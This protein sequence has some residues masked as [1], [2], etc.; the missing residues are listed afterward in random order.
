MGCSGSRNRQTDDTPTSNSGAEQP[1]AQQSGPKLQPGQS[2]VVV[3]DGDIAE[4]VKRELG[5]PQESPQPMIPLHDGD[6]LVYRIPG[7]KKHKTRRAS[8]LW[9]RGQPAPSKHERKST[10]RFVAESPQRQCKKN[11]SE[12]AQ[13]DAHVLRSRSYMDA[14]GEF[15]SDSDTDDE[16][17]SKSPEHE[18]VLSDSQRM[19]SLS[20]GILSPVNEDTIT[21]STRRRQDQSTSSKKQERKSSAVQDLVPHPIWDPQLVA[22]HPLGGFTKFIS[23][24]RLRVVDLFRA[25]DRDVDNLITFDDVYTALIE[26]DIPLPGHSVEDLVN[27]LDENGD[28]VI[29]FPE[30]KRAIEQQKADARIRRRNRKSWTEHPWRRYSI[31]TGRRKP[32]PKAAPVEIPTHVPLTSLT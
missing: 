29:T 25:M 26:L 19:D 15:F 8:I 24:N 23:A 6:T 10:V 18:A 4:R 13:H 21:T 3:G 16:R 32:M 17:V 22:E 27:M 7:K 31:S 9:G 1:Q 14:T 11:A 28:G 20:S 30:F 5:T 12:K 2:V